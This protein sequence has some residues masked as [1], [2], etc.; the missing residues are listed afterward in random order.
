[1]AVASPS[2]RILRY[3]LETTPNTTPAT[4]TM[5][6]FRRVGGGGLGRKRDS[7]ISEEELGHPGEVD[8][9][10]GAKKPSLSLD[11]ELSYGTLDAFLAS[12]LGNEWAANQLKCGT[13]LKTFTI[14][15][16]HPDIGVFLPAKGMIVDSMS[17]NIPSN[18]IIKGSFS[19]AGMSY[20]AVAAATIANTTNP[21]TTTKAM[22]SYTGSIQKGGATIATVTSLGISISGNRTPKFGLMSNEAHHLS[23]GGLKIALDITVFFENGSFLADYDNE[24]EFELVVTPV[25]KAGNSYV[26]TFPRVR[27]SDED[28]DKQ[29][30]D[31]IQKMKGV[32]LW[33]P[34]DTAM[35][36][37]RISA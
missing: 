27:I 13:L 28:R 36:I 29:D 18:G 23:R 1:M 34:D 20:G 5:E 7:F 25:D 16:G 33:D 26:F 11:F 17:L 22:D 19:F 35:T 9:R 12:A 6:T 24:T 8:L 10:L 37:D 30:G 4:P 32:A 3:I 2:E 14:E 21:A 15:D 31:M